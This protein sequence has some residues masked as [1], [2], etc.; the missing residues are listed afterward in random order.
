MKRSPL[1]LL[2]NCRIRMMVAQRRNIKV[3]KPKAIQY[4]FASMTLLR[5]DE[6]VVNCNGVEKR[7]TRNTI[8]LDSYYRELKRK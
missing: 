7:T 5:W 4:R 2:L 8:I 6:M 1:R 3:H